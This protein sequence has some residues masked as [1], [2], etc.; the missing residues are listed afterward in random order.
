MSR[1]LVEW[2]VPRLIWLI[3]WF[4][5]L[6]IRWQHVGNR[7]SAGQAQQAVVTMW[8]ARILMLPYA[9]RGWRGY[10]LVSEHRDGSFISDAINLLGVPTL[11]GSKTRG[12]ARAMLQMVR[13][14]RD[15]NCS[16]G[17]TPD[18]PKGPVEVVKEG[19]AQLAMK[20]GLPV[21]PVC[22]ATR[23]HWRA[24]SWD[25]FYIPKPFTRGVFVYGD[26]VW[27]AADEPMEQAVMRIQQA[28]DAVQ[29]RADSYFGDAER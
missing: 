11:R 2:L 10:M 25:R 6:T 21:Q 12:G 7:F 3:H 18:G 28:M 4:L 29:Q 22:Y 26:Y 9:F 19:T 1:R 5:A 23:R 14:V 13:K 8:H 15:E 24:K 17:I 20:T 16:L 27:I